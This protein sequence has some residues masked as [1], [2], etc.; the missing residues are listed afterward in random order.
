M[1]SKRNILIAGGAGYIGT[2]LSNDLHSRGH[3]VTVVDLFWFGD[4]LCPSVKKIKANILDLQISDVKGF[5][6]VI[7]LGG[8]SNDPI[9]NFSPKANFI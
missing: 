9:A 7:F 8:L 6:S 5:D 4:Y 2:Q 3:N 1:T